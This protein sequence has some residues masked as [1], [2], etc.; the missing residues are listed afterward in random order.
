MRDS[1]VFAAAGLA[2]IA[3]CAAAQVRPL[4]GAQVTTA[5]IATP[6]A[7][8]PKE[9]PVAGPKIPPQSFTKVEEQ[10]NQAL[11]SLKDPVDFLGT[12]RALYLPDYGIVMSSELSLVLTPGMNPFRKGFTKEEVAK[13]HERK[14][15]QV[16]VIKKAMREQMSK[17]ALMLAGAGSIPPQTL[18]SSR[19]QVVVA[20]RVMYLPWEDTTGLPAQII[21]KAPLKD[22]IDGPVKEEVQ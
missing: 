21:L 20:V 10:F 2:L 1:M 16:P 7:P 3:G 11:T 15:A 18:T 19:L 5:S 8:C 4:A 22:A 14:A 17:A 9:T 12:T 13:M 6:A